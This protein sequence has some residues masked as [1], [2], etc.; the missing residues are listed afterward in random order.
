MHGDAWDTVIIPRL[1][2]RHC[3]FTA[4]PPTNVAC[5]PV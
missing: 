1:K 2:V 4:P 3:R 5:S